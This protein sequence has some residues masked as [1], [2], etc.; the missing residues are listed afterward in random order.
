MSKEK[1]HPILH[2]PIQGMPVS[3]EFKVM[4][5][6][7]GYRTLMDIIKNK[8]HQLPL[9]PQSGYRMLREFLDIMEA[10][11]LIEWIEEQHH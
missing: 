7:N 2:E 5:R 4:A 9:Q 11:G 10:H 8:L 3:R 1:E 6:V